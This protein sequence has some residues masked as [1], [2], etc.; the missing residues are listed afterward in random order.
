MTLTYV[1]L[2]AQ[3]LSAAAELVAARCRALQATIPET[4]TRYTEA[5]TILPLLAGLAQQ[6]PGLAALRQGQL[7]GFLLAM[8]LPSF[9]DKRSAYSPEWANGALLAEA[10]TIYQALYAHLAAQWVADGCI[11][12]ALTVLANDTRGLAG[13]YWQGFGLNGVDGVR[14]MAAMVPEPAPFAIRRAT[15]ADVE[16]VATHSLA[17]QEYLARPPIFKPLEEPEGLAYYARWLAEAD[18]VMWLACA[19][20]GAV[21]GSLGLVPATPDARTLMQDPGTLSVMHAYTEPAW[22]GHGVAAALLA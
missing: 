5:E 12:H 14:S 13:W 7:V 22:R 9:R 3:H 18:H 1:A 19:D 8:V 21:V 16:L 11:L 17:L 6:A 2:S 10:D 20:D 15:V 4:P